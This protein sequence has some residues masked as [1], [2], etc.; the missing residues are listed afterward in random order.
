MQYDRVLIDGEAIYKPRNT[1]G[2]QKARESNGSGL[3]V[4]RTPTHPAITE[5][6]KEHWIRP[7]TGSARTSC[8]SLDK[9]PAL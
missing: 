1:Q 9:S 5:G 4:Q 6:T 7:G 2:R 3:T 8:M